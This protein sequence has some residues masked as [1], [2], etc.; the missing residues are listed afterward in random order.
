MRSEAMASMHESYSVKETVREYHRFTL[1]HFS[2]FKQ[3]W[4]GFTHEQAEGAFYDALAD[5]SEHENSDGE[6]TVLVKGHERER[7]ITGTRTGTQTTSKNSGGVGSSSSG[8]LALGSAGAC[9]GPPSMAGRSDHGDE[10]LEGAKRSLGAGD[11]ECADDDNASTAQPSPAKLS[12]SPAP[13]VRRL[14][15]DALKAHMASA[16]SGAAKDDAAENVNLLRSRSELQKE[17]RDSYDEALSSK[18]P[19]T[20]LKK[21]IKNTPAESIALSETDPQGIA[22]GIKRDLIEPLRVLY[23]SSSKLPLK[24]V[25]V[26]KVKLWEHTLGLDDRPVCRQTLP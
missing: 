26:Q 22:D 18:S 17:A 2:A 6:P 7:R 19:Y 8:L 24:E 23:V 10:G 12:K 14:T 5:Q 13:K 1:G 21:K 9:A 15:M 11:D 3:F 20:L 4:D 16:N 25:R